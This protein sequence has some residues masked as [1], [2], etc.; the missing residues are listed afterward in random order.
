ME[1]KLEEMTIRKAKNG[2]HVI[3]HEYER[4]PMHS[5]GAANGGMYM[6]RPKSEEHVFG[7]EDGGKVLKHIQTHLGL[8]AINTADKFDQPTGKDEQE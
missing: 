3:R 2:G 1:K 8:K 6:D 4:K 5:S 7:P